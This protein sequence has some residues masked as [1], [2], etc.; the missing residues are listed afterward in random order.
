M[1]IL[2][3]NKMKNTYIYILM[4]ILFGLSSCLKGNLEDLPEYEDAEINTVS[5]VRYRYISD[6]VSNASGQN[7]VKEVDFT[8]TEEIDQ[9]KATVV[10]TVTPKSDYPN[11]TFDL[12]T[13]KL[14]IAVGL[15]TAAR[16]KPI[17]NSNT[18]GI[19]ALWNEKNRYLVTAADGS[20]KEWSITVIKK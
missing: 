15:S 3:H 8:H 7:I 6:D 19:P 11:A 9:E 12:A 14:V 17:E 4:L 1:V 10:I 20:T 13:D 5:A 16:I 2:K 18:L